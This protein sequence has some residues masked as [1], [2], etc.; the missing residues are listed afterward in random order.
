MSVMAA[1]ANR[2]TE[3]LVLAVTIDY[4]TTHLR[5]M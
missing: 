3:H 2:Q 4:R 1:A 5:G